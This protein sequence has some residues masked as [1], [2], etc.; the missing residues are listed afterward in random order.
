VTVADFGSRERK[1][2]S[3]ISDAAAVEVLWPVEMAEGHIVK[4]RRKDVR[5]D[6]MRTAD[7]NP[8]LGA[9]TLNATRAVE[10]PS[11]D[12]GKITH[13]LFDSCNDV[14]MEGPCCGF[15]AEPSFCV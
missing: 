3:G 13:D 15:N 12:K 5:R 4:A 1:A 6:R 11:G 10:V 14:R 2:T 9:F 8:A 7:Q